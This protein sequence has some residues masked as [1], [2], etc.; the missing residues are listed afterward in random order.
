MVGSKNSNGLDGGAE[1]PHS[2]GKAKGQRAMA[3]RCQE[4]LTVLACIRSQGLGHL[5]QVLAKIRL[6]HRGDALAP[7]LECAE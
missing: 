4:R 3:G 1:I 5:A 6:R 7:P 2:A